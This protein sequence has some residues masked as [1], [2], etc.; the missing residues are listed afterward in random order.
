MVSPLICRRRGW[1]CKSPC[2]LRAVPFYRRTGVKSR[3]RT[4]ARTFRPPRG[5]NPRSLSFDQQHSRAPRRALVLILQLVV[6][7]F[8]SFLFC[9]FLCLSFS[10]VL[11]L[12]FCCFIIIVLFLRAPAQA[13][14]LVFICLFVCVFVFI[15]SSIVPIDM[16]VRIYAFHVYRQYVCMYMYMCIIKS[17]LLLVL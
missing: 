5:K 13:V 8:F 2:K 10:F 16:L 11:F 15:L 3:R 14:V 4:T 17:C 7:L 1:P 6:L 12:I 9:S